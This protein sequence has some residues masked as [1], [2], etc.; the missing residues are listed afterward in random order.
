MDFCEGGGEMNFRKRVF[1]LVGK[2]RILLILI[3]A[4]FIFFIGFHAGSS[5]F[6]EKNEK[7]KEDAFKQMME[8]K[9]GTPEQT[10]AVLTL[11]RLNAKESA[12]SERLNFWMT[13]L[14]SILIAI[15]ISIHLIEKRKLKA[16]AIEFN[17]P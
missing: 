16:E 14:P 15:D 10:E 11:K 1:D 8:A 6:S 9:S 2:A 4:T 17:E 3:A 5:C 13:L 12:Q 7:A